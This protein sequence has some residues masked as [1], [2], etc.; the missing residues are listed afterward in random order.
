M[1]HAYIVLS[2]EGHPLKLG[3]AD[4]LWISQ[5]T[6]TIF[7]DRPAAKRAMRRTDTYAAKHNLPWGSSRLKRLVPEKK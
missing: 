7:G 3:V 4:V 2:H 6:V 5:S 1:K